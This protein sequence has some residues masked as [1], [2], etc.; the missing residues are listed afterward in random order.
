MDPMGNVYISLLV[1]FDML[2]VKILSYLM[3]V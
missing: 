3:E 2:L 1:I